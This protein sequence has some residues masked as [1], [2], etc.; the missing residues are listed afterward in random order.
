L[1]RLD[2]VA[3]GHYGDYKALGDGVY[4]LRLAF[5]PGYRVYFC[6]Y[7]NVTVIL[8]IAG[9]KSRQSKDIALAK[10]YC[11]ELRGNNHEQAIND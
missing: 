1:R 4:E 2:R 7:D 3:L 10:Q 9:D 11:R 6:E 5:G 8:L